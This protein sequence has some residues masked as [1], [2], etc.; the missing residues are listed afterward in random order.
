MYVK[1]GQKPPG[2]PKPFIYAW[3]R[4]TY[5]IVC[6]KYCSIEQW[7]KNE[8]DYVVEGDSKVALLT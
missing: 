7:K 1:V 3:V 8:V 2:I 6:E 4:V 5:N